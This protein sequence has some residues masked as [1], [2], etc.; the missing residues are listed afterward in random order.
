MEKELF[1]LIVYSENIA[2]LLNQVTAEFTRRQM[3]IE[4]L[5][6]S[7]SSIKD[8]HR[9]T[10]TLWSDE[11]TI[12]KVVKR[13]EK[14]IDVVKADY[15]TDNEIFMQEVALFKISTPILLDNP[16][17][18]KTIRRYGARIMEANAVYAVVEKSGV[19]DE[20]HALH[21]ELDNFGCVLQYVSSGRIAVT[22]DT[23]EHVNEYLEK[24]NKG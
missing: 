8:V 4:T 23:A 10:I 6:V 14:K 7:S 2:G 1:T 3:N 16:L 5:N 9:Y 18:S 12:K 21:T 15:Y 24:I 19:T 17:I 22:R 11:E 20:I 13:L